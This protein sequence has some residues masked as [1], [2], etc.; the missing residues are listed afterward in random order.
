MDKIRITATGQNWSTIGRL[1]LDLGHDLVFIGEQSGEPDPEG[2]YVSPGCWLKFYVRPS[3]KMPAAIADEI[4]NRKTK[5]QTQR[6][7]VIAINEA[8]DEMSKENREKYGVDFIPPHIL[9]NETGTMGD[10]LRG[11]K[12]RATL[13]P[14]CDAPITKNMIDRGSPVLAHDKTLGFDCM[15]CGHRGLLSDL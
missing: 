7:L 9:P 6:A 4:K 5:D 11:W 14:D 1:L 13:C 10:P 2:S 3:M 8:V 12:F 15:N